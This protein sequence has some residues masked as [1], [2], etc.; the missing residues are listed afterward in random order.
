MHISIFMPYYL[1]MCLSISKQ[2]L[3]WDMVY[4]CKQ[5]VLDKSGCGSSCDLFLAIPQNLFGGIIENNRQ[6]T[7]PVLQ[8]N[9]Q[10]QDC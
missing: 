1:Y 8:A 6:S 2:F 3:Y 5:M 9:I 10:T 4:K 7:I